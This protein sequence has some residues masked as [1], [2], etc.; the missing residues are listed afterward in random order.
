MHPLP[1]LGSIVALSLVIFKE[2]IEVFGDRV[3]AAFIHD[4]ETIEAERLEGLHVFSHYGEVAAEPFEMGLIDE[5][6]RRR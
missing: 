4:V 3:I 6:R 1:I 5:G 2:V